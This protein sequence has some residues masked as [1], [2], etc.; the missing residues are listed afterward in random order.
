MVP[1]AWCSRNCIAPYR[2][3]GSDGTLSGDVDLCPRISRKNKKNL[4]SA[5][6]LY[7]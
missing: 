3:P 5:S 2:Y 6:S 4:G 7:E 1:V